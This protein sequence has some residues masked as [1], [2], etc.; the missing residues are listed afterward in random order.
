MA[1]RVPAGEGSKSQATAK[2]KTDAELKRAIAARKY[3]CTDAEILQ[4][5]RVHW[6]AIE[7]EVIAR[8]FATKSE[9]E[10]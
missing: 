9:F 3:G 6:I 4:R 7:K 1:Q 2:E 10:R 5:F 8:G